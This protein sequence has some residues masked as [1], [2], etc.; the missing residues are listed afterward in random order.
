M[1]LLPQA[2]FQKLLGERH[3]ARA[4][5]SCEADAAAPPRVDARFD[6]P[7]PAREAGDVDVGRVAPTRAGRD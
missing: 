5:I 1:R 4:T 3:G 7:R 6:G 2:P